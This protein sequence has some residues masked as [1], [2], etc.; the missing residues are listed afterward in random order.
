MKIITSLPM[1]FTT[2]SMALQDLLGESLH[3]VESSL[4]Q[5]SD[6]WENVV[7]GPN[8]SNQRWISD[9]RMSKDVFKKIVNSLRPML[10]KKTTNMRATISTEKRVAITL[11]KLV[12]PNSYRA[13][14]AQFGVGVLTVCVIV[15]EVCRAINGTLLHKVICFKSIDTI[16][17]GFK[18]HGSPH[19]MGA[20]YGSHI[21]IHA[22][23]EE[24]ENYVCR[25]KYYSIVLQAVADSELLFRDVYVG[26]AGSAH[27]S[28]ILHSSPLFHRK[29]KG[30][31]RP[32][33]VIVIDNMPVHPVLLGDKAYPQVPWLLRVYDDGESTAADRYNL[34]FNNCRNFVERAFGLLK[35]CF[36]MLL[37]CADMRLDNA[38][39]AVVTCCILHNVIQ[40]D[41]QAL[42]WNEDAEPDA[43]DNN[44][45][46]PDVG[47]IPR[48]VKLLGSAVRDSFCTH[49]E[50]EH[51]M[52]IRWQPPQPK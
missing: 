39:E 17:D 3:E 4:Q 32:D 12:T 11:W 6:W 45:Q 33:P 36:Q 19:C 22:P 31:L 42:N 41:G 20:V 5:S 30:I 35:G 24:P 51:N 9:F 1:K 52:G 49:F 28:Q 48:G 8:Y 29:Y 25:K 10:S 47:N 27:D 37:K 16:M 44:I 2:A 46:V 21:E 26:Y 50:R 40:T 38:E 7:N 13:V 18:R 14:A 43:P 23:E 15:K 34:R